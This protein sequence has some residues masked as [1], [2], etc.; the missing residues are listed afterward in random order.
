VRLSSPHAAFLQD[1]CE[2]GPDCSVSGK[3]LQVAWQVWCEDN[4][5]VAGSSSSFMVRL[6]AAVPGLRRVRRAN[7]PSQYTCV[8]LTLKEELVVRALGPRLTDFNDPR[9]SF[10]P[11]VRM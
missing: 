1:C 10:G 9:P 2:V 11:K 3:I 4:R 8:G 5:H 6:K 7:D